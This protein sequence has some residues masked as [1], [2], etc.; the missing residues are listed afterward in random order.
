MESEKSKLLLTMYVWVR[1][2][3][4]GEKKVVKKEYSIVKPKGSKLIYLGYSTV[5]RLEGMPRLWLVRHSSLTEIRMG[6][7]FIYHNP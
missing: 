3:S 7:P 1:V 6:I 4:E 2:S 5:Y